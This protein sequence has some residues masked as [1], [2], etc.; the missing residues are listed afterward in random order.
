MAAIDKLYLNDYYSFDEL[1]R[2]VIIH[3]PSMLNNMINPFMSATE[4]YRRVECSFN[5][6]QTRAKEFLNSVGYHDKDDFVN[7]LKQMTEEKVKKY[8]GKNGKLRFYNSVDDIKDDCF[9]ELH[10][11]IHYMEMSQTTYAEKYY[12]MPVALFTLAQDRFLKWHCGLD[13]VRDYLH[14][15][16]AVKESHD[17]FYSLFFFK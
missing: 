3:K 16:C 11:N 10:S 7:V 4:F 13:F 2:W 6:V 1:R 5:D 15:Q 9:A 12:Q 17:K 8:T 14:E